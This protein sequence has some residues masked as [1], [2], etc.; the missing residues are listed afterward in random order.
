MVSLSSISAR[1]ESRPE[2][3]TLISLTSL[4]KA[5]SVLTSP[6]PEM[7]KCPMGL[8]RLPAIIKL[9][10]S[11]ET[12]T[13]PS[14]SILSSVPIPSSFV[15]R[16]TTLANCSGSIV[17]SLLVAAR[18]IFLVMGISGSRAADTRAISSPET[19]LMRDVKPSIKIVTSSLF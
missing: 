12:I 19:G 1:S 5:S 17:I 3:S 9:L 7:V 14:D 4:R 15:P 11:V 8:S 13:F 16:V 18:I 10:P 6:S 2:I